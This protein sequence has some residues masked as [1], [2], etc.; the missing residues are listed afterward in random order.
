MKDKAEQ[1]AELDRVAASRYVREDGRVFY[2]EKLPE[3]FFSNGLCLLHG[4]KAVQMQEQEEVT[5]LPFEKNREDHHP[6][7]WEYIRGD[8]QWGMSHYRGFQNLPS[9]P[10]PEALGPHGGEGI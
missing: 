1:I 6:N 10:P 3:Y 5:I 2:R 7:Y 4:G 8:G 9:Q